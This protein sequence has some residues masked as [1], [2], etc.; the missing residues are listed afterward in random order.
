MS[1]KCNEANGGQ[2]MVLLATVS[3]LTTI[4]KADLTKSMKMLSVLDF[5]PTFDVYSRSQV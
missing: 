2:N 3:A 5:R 1:V 4:S